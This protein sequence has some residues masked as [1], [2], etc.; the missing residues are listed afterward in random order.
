MAQKFL[1][2]VSYG[3]CASEGGGTKNINNVY[4]FYRTATTLPVSKV[5]IDAAFQASIMT[6]VLAA[7]S[8][9]Y[10][11]IRNSYRFFDDATDAPISFSYTGP[12]LITGERLPVYTA[13]TIQI[14]TG[15]RGRIYRG[16]KH[17]SP[18]GESQSNGDVL[19]AGSI[20]LFNAIATALQTGLLDSDGNVW[21][22]GIKSSKP[23]AQYL[24][25]PTSVV[26]TPISSAL[27]NKTT[28]TMRRRKVRTV[29]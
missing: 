14:K 13:A 8:L 9:D 19:V 17:Y 26:F 23:P 24:T 22:T 12:G 2:V 21:I 20:T 7:L 1:E 18:L 5:N 28:G 27:L 6:P 3:S 10:T 4:N 25:N 11:Q 29:N 16:S 15:L